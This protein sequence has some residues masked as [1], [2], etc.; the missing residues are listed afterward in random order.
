[1]ARRVTQAIEKNMKDKGDWARGGADGTD[2]MM[3][4]TTAKQSATQSPVTNVTRKGD[5]ISLERRQ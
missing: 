5:R 1:M 3:R 4:R 2:M